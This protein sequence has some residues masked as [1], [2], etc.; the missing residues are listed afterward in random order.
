MDFKEL[1]NQLS[2]VNEELR[3]HGLRAIN[4]SLTLRN[5]FFGFYI[6]EFEQHGKDRAKY[7]DGLLK[8]IAAEI[9]M[10][11]VSNA[12]ERELRRYRQFYEIY[13]KIVTCISLNDQVRSLLPAGSLE[14][15]MTG[16]SIRGSVNP[17][18][19]VPDFH[20][21]NLLSNISYTH[22]KELVRL[23]DPVFA[24]QCAGRI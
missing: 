23:E 24:L 16:D 12:D 13:P 22:F 18:I 11:G 21:L 2:K 10:L 3:E 20:Y 15:S 5:W 4:T 8:K 9:R 19:Q 17:E 7:G 14:S 6:L 1:I